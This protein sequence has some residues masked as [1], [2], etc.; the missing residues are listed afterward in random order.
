MSVFQLLRTIYSNNANVELCDPLPMVSPHHAGSLPDGAVENLTS[1]Y[2][3]I[4][5]IGLFVICSVTHA[6]TD[7]YLFINC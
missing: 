5:Y 4:V 6:L 7:S 2:D 1:V 3:S